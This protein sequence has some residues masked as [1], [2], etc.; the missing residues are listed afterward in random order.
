MPVKRKYYGALIHIGLHQ[1]PNEPLRID[2]DTVQPVQQVRD[3]DI[4]VDRG[5]TM[6]VHISKTV[7]CCFAA[8]RQIC[9]SQRSVSKPVLLS[10]VT[11]RVLSCL[12]YGSATLAG[13]PKYLLDRLQSIFNAA[14]RARKYDHV[15]PLLQELHWLS[16]SERIKYRLAVLVF[17]CR[18]DMAPDY[19]ARDLQWAADTDSRQR[20]RSSSSQQLIVPRT[21]SSCRCCCCSYLEQ[22]TSDSDLRCHTP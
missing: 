8:L 14:A 2:C 22:S 7:A 4:F 11:S 1:L 17:R 13:I 18:Y 20:L 21:R 15:S 16:V 3:L 19:M 5:I 12:N 10:L 6:A 9:S